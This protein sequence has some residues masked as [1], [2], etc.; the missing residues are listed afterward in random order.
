MTGV[1]AQD[2]HACEQVIERGLATFV[3]VGQALMRIRDSRL[4]RDGY[5]SFEAY[6]RDRWGMDK[7]SAIRHITAAEVV[8]SIDT[9]ADGPLPVNVGQA[10]ELAPLRDDPPDTR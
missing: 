10:R 7:V 2:L 1:V 6:C 4:Y 9:I 3:D 5:P 8:V